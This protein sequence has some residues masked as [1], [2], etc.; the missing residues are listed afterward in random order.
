MS[1]VKEKVH[2]MIDELPE[3]CTIEDIQYHLYVREKIEHGLRD[4][5]KGRSYSQEEA[6]K[7]LAR[8]Q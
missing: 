7:R 8:W 5:E 4:L 1:A 6:R 2:K 3:D